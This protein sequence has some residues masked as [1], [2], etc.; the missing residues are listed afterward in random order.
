MSYLQ[1]LIC[2]FGAYNGSYRL[3]CGTGTKD[4]TRLG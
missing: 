1:Q 2:K 3:V 4:D